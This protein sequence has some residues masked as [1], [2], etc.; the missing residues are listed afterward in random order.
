M[1][2]I[3]VVGVEEGM[4]G[5]RMDRSSITRTRGTVRHRR[6]R[7]ALVLDFQVLPRARTRIGE[8]ITGRRD[9]ASFPVV[10]PDTPATSSSSHDANQDHEEE[11][12]ME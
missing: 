3:R 7:Q 11:G 6:R 10:T 5:R 1:Q 8:Q 9:G 2:L 12:N 4:K